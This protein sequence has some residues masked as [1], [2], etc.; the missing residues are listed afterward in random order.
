MASEAIGG[1]RPQAAVLL[2]GLVVYPAGLKGTAASTWM[3]IPPLSAC[4]SESVKRLFCFVNL[5]HDKKKEENSLIAPSFRGERDTT[6]YS[7]V[8]KSPR[9]SFSLISPRYS[10]PSRPLLLP[11]FPPPA[12]TGLEEMNVCKSAS[13]ARRG[14]SPR[15]RQLCFL[16]RLHC[17]LSRSSSVSVSCINVASER[18]ACLSFLLVTVSGVRVYIGPCRMPISG[19]N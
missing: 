7:V 5:S 4:G 16:N 1:R 14:A 15:P 8:S 18:H 6:R 2:T 19:S 3:L 12:L 10:L 13:V 17:S 11:L 9:V